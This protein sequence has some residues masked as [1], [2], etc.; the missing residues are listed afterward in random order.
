MTKVTGQ[1]EMLRLPPTTLELTTAELKAFEH[2]RRFRKTLGKLEPRIFAT[3][4]DTTGLAIPKKRATEPL[5]SLVQHR[6]GTSTPSI[7]EIPE[8]QVAV[9]SQMQPDATQSVPSPGAV[10]CVSL[11]LHCGGPLVT[12]LQHLK[13]QSV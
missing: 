6:H 11:S 7:D 10:P 13:T 1:V 8:Q 9:E 12:S 2:R 4:Q 5:D 3:N